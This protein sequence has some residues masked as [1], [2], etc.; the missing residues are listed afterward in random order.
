[1]SHEL[2]TECRPQLSE[3]SSVNSHPIAMT[4]L[5]MLTGY[6][7]NSITK[8]EYGRHLRQISSSAYEHFG[9]EPK[10]YGPNK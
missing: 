4:G 2:L 8:E 7:Q 10:P 6:W 5:A 1:M 3:R 9:A